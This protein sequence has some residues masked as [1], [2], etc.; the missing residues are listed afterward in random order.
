MWLRGILGVLFC[1][2]GVIW[3]G[4]GLGSVHGSFMTGE[5]RWTFFGVIAVLIGLTLLSLARRA[6]SSSEAAPD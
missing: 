4:Q 5:T 3:I 1:I 6:R 2:T